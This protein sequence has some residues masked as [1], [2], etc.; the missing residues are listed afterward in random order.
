VT[1]RPIF[2]Q[3]HRLRRL[4]QLVLAKVFPKGPVDA[5][6]QIAFFLG[7]YMAYRYTQGAIDD[8]IGTATSFSNARDLIGIEQATG[9]FV[10]PSIHQFFRD[11]GPA[12]DFA[13]LLYMNA[14]TMIVSAALLFIYF[15]HNSS[16][17]FVRNMFLFAMAIAL[18]CY[19][20]FPTAPPR[21]FLAEYG[22]VDIVS[23][24]TGVRPGSNVNDLFNPYA[25]VPSMHCAFAL[26]IAV[27]LAKLSK[28]K[29]TRIFW[30]C[31]PAIMVW[32]VIVTANHWWLDA[33]AGFATAGVAA[34]AAGVLARARP[35]AWAFGRAGSRSSQ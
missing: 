8:P 25:A 3:L 32:C 21:F 12:R 34:Y 20:A 29:V 17:Y 23:N 24:I 4:S 15:R 11:I 30:T 1:A 27:P 35:Q 19:A 28:H 26:M 14:Q 18:V 31:Y 7:C 2:T 16:F 9:T 10:E 5:L 13:A 22:F 6:R 33:A